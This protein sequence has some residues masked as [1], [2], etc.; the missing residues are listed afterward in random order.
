VVQHLQ[1]NG[2]N[3]L[4]STRLHKPLSAKSWQADDRS[5]H[6]SKPENDHKESYE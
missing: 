2:Q 5:T 6:C 3:H 1:V 4:L